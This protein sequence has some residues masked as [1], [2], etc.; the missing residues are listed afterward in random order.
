VYAEYLLPTIIDP[1]LD[2]WSIVVNQMPLWAGLDSNSN[3]N[4]FIFNPP[5]S[6][7]GTY[8]IGFDLE[9]TSNSIPYSF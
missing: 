3:P 1:E 9:D 8:T 5:L 6:S 7:A 4:T 2:E